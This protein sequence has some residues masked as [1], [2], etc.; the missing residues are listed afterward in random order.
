MQKDDLI[1]KVSMR[2]NEAWEVANLATKRLL[3]LVSILVQMGG[4]SHEDLLACAKLETSLRLPLF[5]GE[6]RRA[7]VCSRCTWSMPS[8][9][10]GIGGPY[11]RL[12]ECREWQEHGLPRGI[13]AMSLPTRGKHSS[14]MGGCNPR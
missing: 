4:L 1:T 3:A 9:R 12:G 13:S 8:F 14:I 11:R 7:Q 6:I 2:T 10:Q 5:K